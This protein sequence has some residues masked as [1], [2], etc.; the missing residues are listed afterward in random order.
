[1][2]TESAAILTID[3]YEREVEILTIDIYEREVE[4]LTIEIYE[5]EVEILTIDIY[6]REVEILT[7]DIY[8]RSG[9]YICVQDERNCQKMV[10][11]SADKTRL[12]RFIYTREKNIF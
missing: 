10:L 6:E 9:M 3:I 12:T 11:P 1:L 8:E 5:R 7:I 4:I 2:L